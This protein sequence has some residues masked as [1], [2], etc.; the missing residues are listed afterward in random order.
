MGKGQWIVENLAWL[1]NEEVNLEALPADLRSG[2]N[3]GYVGFK[4]TEIA[5]AMGI[6]V[7]ELFRANE[8]GQ[9]RLENKP[10]KP[11]TGYDEGMLFRLSFGECYCVAQA[12][13]S[14]SP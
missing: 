12:A 3:L 6:T 2:L 11:E 14:R 4:A 7:E 5:E 13:P 9:L 1:S 10:I 8:A